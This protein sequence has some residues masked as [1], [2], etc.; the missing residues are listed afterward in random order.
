MKLRIKFD[1]WIE[2]S[3]KY[4]KLRLL[5]RPATPPRKR[6]ATPE[7]EKILL[8]VT[9]NRWKEGINKK[10]IQKIGP[11]KWRMNISK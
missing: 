8:I 5:V 6:P 1:D 7:K 9:L 11:N 10:I 3:K 4:T 2:K